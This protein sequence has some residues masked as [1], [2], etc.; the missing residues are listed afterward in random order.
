MRSAPA[1]SSSRGPAAGPL[2]EHA[3]LVEGAGLERRPQAHGRAARDALPLARELLLGLGEQPRHERCGLRGALQVELGDLRQRPLRA[4]TVAVPGLHGREAHEGA[5]RLGGIGVL[6]HEPFPRELGGRGTARGELGAGG[7]VEL[8]R[9]GL[10]HRAL[11]EQAEARGS[12][13]ASDS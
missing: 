10:A 5:G 3:D 1:T 6:V 2:R 13:C 8:G 12:P 4:G 7:R 11:R 9:R